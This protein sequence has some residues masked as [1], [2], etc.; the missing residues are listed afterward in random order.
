MLRYAYTPQEIIKLFDEYYK[1]YSSGYGDVKFDWHYR[2]SGKNLELSYNG[3]NF[4]IPFKVLDEITRLYVREY[5]VDE[6]N[7]VINKNINQN[8][9]QDC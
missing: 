2:E 6:I 4:I 7:K 8:K 9:M 1:T 5:T 3:K